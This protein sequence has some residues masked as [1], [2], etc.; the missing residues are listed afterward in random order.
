MKKVVASSPFSGV[1]MSEVADF[2]IAPDMFTNDW[3]LKR[4]RDYARQIFSSWGQTKVVEDNFNRMRLREVTDTRNKTHTPLT[5]W[6]MAREMGAIQSHQREDVD[7]EQGS[8]GLDGPR[9]LGKDL[10]Y[11]KS[12]NL[13]VTGAEDIMGTAHWPTFSAQTAQF[14]YGCRNVSGMN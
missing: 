6:S 14:Q 8:G 11:T 9:K 10:F 4:F 12:H 7:V 2:M 1:L 3:K 5:Y 13:E